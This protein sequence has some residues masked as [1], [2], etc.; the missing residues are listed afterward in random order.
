MPMPFSASVLAMVLASPRFSLPSVTMTIRLAESSGNEA[1][2]SFR[3]DGDVRRVGPHL[4]QRF[5]LPG[6]DGADFVGKR[7][8]LDR[9]FAAEDDDARFV[10]GGVL[11]IARL[12]RCLET[13][14]ITYFSIAS[15]VIL[16]MLSDW[17]SRYITVTRSLILLS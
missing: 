17:S 2:A 5:E 10:L 7:R 11:Q 9:R 6:A 1:W 15:R 13:S 8:I 4:E 14:S 16:G 12:R 3:A